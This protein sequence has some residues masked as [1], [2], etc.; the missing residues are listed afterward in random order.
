MSIQSAIGTAS[1]STTTVTEASAE[2]SI[3]ASEAGIESR[4]TSIE[5]E[6]S[7]VTVSITASAGTG[8]KTA[9]RTVCSALATALL[10]LFRTRT[11]A[12]PTPWRAAGARGPG[13]ATFMTERGVTLEA[14]TMG[15][16]PAEEVSWVWPT[17]ERVSAQCAGTTQAP[18]HIMTG[19]STSWL[20]ALAVTAGWSGAFPSHSPTCRTASPAAASTTGAAHQ[21]LE[22]R[23]RGG[24][25]WKASPDIGERA[26]MRW[27][28]CRPEHPAH[29]R[30]G[31]SFS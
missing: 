18:G 12:T 8:S 30:T 19:L 6:G 25:R 5:S 4:T 9:S 2:S 20:A 14:T 3:A 21:L 23:R 1:R 13:A 31:Q 10:R 29:Q 15:W 27:H 11:C 16:N 26:P 17:T 24:T 7:S 22:T 28:L